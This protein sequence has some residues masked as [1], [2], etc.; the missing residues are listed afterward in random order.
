MSVCPH[1]D[2]KLVLKANTPTIVDQSARTTLDNK[3]VLKANTPTIVAKMTT[4]SI[5]LTNNPASPLPACP[6]KQDKPQRKT[7]ILPKKIVK[8]PVQEKSAVERFITNKYNNH[9]SKTNS[10]HRK[11]LAFLPPVM[12]EQ[13]VKKPE[14]RSLFTHYKQYDQVME[15]MNAYHTHAKHLF[16]FDAIKRDL[17]K[18]DNMFPLVVDNPV[19]EKMYFI[20]KRDEENHYGSFNL[21]VAFDTINP[22]FY[23]HNQRFYQFYALMCRR[24]GEYNLKTTNFDGSQCFGR[25]YHVYSL[26]KN[27]SYRYVKYRFHTVSYQSRR[28][29][30]AE[31]EA[32]YDL[33]KTRLGSFTN[34]RGKVV[35]D[36]KDITHKELT[37]YMLYDD[38]RSTFDTQH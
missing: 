34:K 10:L 5:A 14:E 27:S 35:R 18:Q 1:L 4:I 33:V 38:L 37:K 36:I 8:V 2:N 3:L 25:R 6:I 7:R 13:L 21:S 16:Y 26:I 20:K 23:E 28:L 11:L 12:R 9:L 17:K 22:N 30:R 15:Q 32:L 24:I 19:V 31:K 29:D